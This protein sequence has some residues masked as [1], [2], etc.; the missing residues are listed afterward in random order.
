MC[1]NIFFSIDITNSFEIPADFD[2][3][4]I[5]IGLGSILKTYQTTPDPYQAWLTNNTNIS[6]AIYALKKYA[7]RP[8]SQNSN[9]NCIDPRSYFYLRDFIH[10]N[11]QSGKNQLS[12]ATTWIQSIS[13]DRVMFYKGYRM[14]FNVNNVDLTVCTN[15]I[16]GL[17][18]AVL[19]N[20]QDPDSWFDDDVQMIYDNTTLLI[21]YEISNNFSS[22]PDL[23]LTYYPSIY[24]F[25]WF[26][27]RTLSLL[28]SQ[29]SLPYPVLERAKERLN[30]ALR[31]AAT[32]D[33]LKRAQTEKDEVYFDD[34]LGDAD[35]NIIGMYT[36]HRNLV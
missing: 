20:L 34:F 15:V 2:D 27:A 5:N 33:I 24:N 10:D 21:A 31:N 36:F 29:D 23:A 32:N 25:Y 17:T 12:L 9:E 16:Y 1:I 7:Y 18:S 26:T 19:S 30:N 8:L 22:R 4:F 3:T 11:L 14:P 28:N 13:E 6:S 35:K